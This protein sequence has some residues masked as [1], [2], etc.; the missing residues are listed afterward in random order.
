MDKDLLEKA[1]KVAAKHPGNKQASVKRAKNTKASAGAKKAKPPKVPANKDR[2]SVPKKKKKQT[3]GNSS[4]IDDDGSASSSK[5][6]VQINVPEDV[7]PV[8]QAHAAPIVPN[9]EENDQYELHAP[10]H[11]HAG[12]DEADAAVMTDNADCDVQGKVTCDAQKGI[13]S[14]VTRKRAQSTLYAPTRS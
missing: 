3:V 13:A 7:A 1:L 6:V 4:L 14:F 11:L 9:H 12:A 5:N 10:A 8:V 2:E